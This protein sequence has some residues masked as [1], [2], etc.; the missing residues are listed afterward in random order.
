[1]IGMAS[2]VVFS[3]VD[4]RLFPS[5]ASKDLAA[6]KLIAL[7]ARALRVRHIMVAVRSIPTMP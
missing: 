3:D 5:T 6:R 4:H 7:S 2:F 1:M